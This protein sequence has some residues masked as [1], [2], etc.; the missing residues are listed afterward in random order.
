MQAL[1]P[2]YRN[3][4]WT[5]HIEAGGM[6]PGSPEMAGHGRGSCRLIQDGLWIDCDFQQEQ[7]LTD[8]TLVL[9]WRLHW[10]TGC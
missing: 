10:I 4:T 3:V 1:R 2:F 6:G 5:G 9:T 8:G 7:R